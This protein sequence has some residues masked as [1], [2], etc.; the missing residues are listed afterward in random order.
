MIY[1]RAFI[2]IITCPLMSCD[3]MC[4]NDFHKHSITRAHT[5]NLQDFLEMCQVT[6]PGYTCMCQLG[7]WL[8]CMLC[9]TAMYINC[10]LA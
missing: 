8:H 6:I 1:L 4:I 5:N 10:D 9:I 7:C 2:P 3:L